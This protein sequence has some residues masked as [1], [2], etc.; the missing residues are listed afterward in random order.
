MSR[1]EWSKQ[2]KEM[3]KAVLEVEGSDDRTYLPDSETKKVQ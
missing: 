2:I 3:E 1:E